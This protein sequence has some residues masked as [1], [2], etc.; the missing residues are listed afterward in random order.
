MAKRLLSNNEI[1][2]GR[3]ILLATDSLD[4]STEG[5]FWL[6]DEE[7]DE[8][9][10]FLVTS[11]FGRI[12]PRE[13]YACLNEALAK[14]LSEHE[15]EDFNLYITDSNDKLVVGL[16]EHIKTGPYVSEPKETTI[17]IDGKNV[18]A[19]VY[20]LTSRLEQSEAKRAQRRFRRSCRVVAEAKEVVAAA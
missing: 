8:W 4:M 1:A 14:K 19:W 2:F 16:R 6:Y 15:T 12:D 3:A 20:R 17:S 13:I 5:A 11:L 18:A 7:D 9:R 10:Y